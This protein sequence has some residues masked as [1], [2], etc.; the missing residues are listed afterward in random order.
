MYEITNHTNSQ[1]RD[2]HIDIAKGIGI[3]AVIGLHTGFHVSAWVGWEMP[4]FFFISGIFANPYKKG[5]IIS[6]INRLLVPA[7]FFYTPIFLYNCA[8]YII[9]QGDISLYD[10]FMNCAIPSALWFLIA[11]FYISL[12]HFVISQIINQKIWFV[13]IAILLSL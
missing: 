13:M 6:R 2:L 7:C 3:L 8:F 9:N 11:L 12:F 5:F 10:C 1:K 4:L